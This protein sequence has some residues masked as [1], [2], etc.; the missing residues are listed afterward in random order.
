MKKNLSNNKN[1]GKYKNEITN[2]IDTMLDRLK[3]NGEYSGSDPM[4]DIL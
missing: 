3:R 1:T 2:V 4:K